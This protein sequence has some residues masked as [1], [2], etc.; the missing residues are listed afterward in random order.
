MKTVNKI[1]IGIV[2][3]LGLGAT[4][5]TVYAQPGPMGMMGYG[6]M[7]GGGPGMMGY[8]MMGG[9]GPG[10]MG[11]RVLA[12]NQ[13]FQQLM[14]PEERTALMEKMSKATTIEERQKMATANFAEMEKRAKEKGIALPAQRSP[15][16]GRGQNCG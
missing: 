5:A 2:A 1:T 13:A 12:S 8:G 6:M 15:Q 11:G 9:G 7:G 4:A 10:M 3:I 16:S 14:S